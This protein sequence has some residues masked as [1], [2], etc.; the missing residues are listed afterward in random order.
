[1]AE[2]T[3]INQP[4]NGQLGDF[5]TEA[6][7]RDVYRE[8]NAVVAFAK[9]SGVLRLK[10]SIESYRKGG[11]HVKI[12]VG[13][14][15]D[16][17]SYEALTSLLAISDE[18]YVVHT[19]SSQTFHP[20]IYRFMGDEDS[21]LIIGSNN[22]TSG[23]L[24]SN[25]ETCAV[26]GYSSDS[27]E[28]NRI[29]K[30]ISEYMSYLVSYES[31]SRRITTQ[32]DIEELY[33]AGYIDKEAKIR[34]RKISADRGESVDKQKK[35]LFTTQVPAHVPSVTVPRAPQT[36]KRSAPVLGNLASLVPHQTESAVSDQFMWFQTGKMT[37][38]S[39]NILDLSKTALVVKGSPIGTMF[40]QGQE[41]VM[42]GG[43]EFFG[44]DPANED[45]TK[46][47]TI[48]Y[49]GVDYSGNTIKYPTGD[50]ANGTWR[51]QIK[52]VSPS[53]V[54]I[55]QALGKDELV[56]KVLA[57]TRISDDYFYLSIF[58]GDDLSQFQDTS[59]I[60]A[61]NGTTTRSRFMGL[62]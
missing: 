31:L 38:G 32:D 22:M 58:A 1:M 39:R 23:G 25:F 33:Q 41:D 40:D 13:I 47:I 54:K 16:G 3:V 35:A 53:G 21:L 36:A 17:T 42:G 50:K 8:F 6:L 5:L 15:L 44:V 7:K 37:G 34:I 57:F 30:E 49:D 14:D 43:T 45:I 2:I 46:D 61:H 11:S 48:N 10:D 62:L 19:E 27:E 29:Q 26:L 60:V 12:F 52:G 9:N 28:G 51:L 56:E 24:W 59:R 55:T 4:R 20:K 18:L